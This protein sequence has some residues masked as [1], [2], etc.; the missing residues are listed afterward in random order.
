MVW[1]P[2]PVAA[3]EPGVTCPLRRWPRAIAALVTALACFASVASTT[4]AEGT[5]VYSVREGDTIFGLAQQFGVSP[6]D[7]AVQNSLTDPNVLEIGQLLQIKRPEPL[8]PFGAMT[9][10]RSDLAERAPAN[11]MDATPGGSGQPVG[12]SGGPILLK[13]ADPAGPNAAAVAP[14]TPV[15]VPRP[16]PP[17]PRPPASHPLIAA[18]YYS[19]FDGTVWAQSNCGPT[20][21]SMAL[22]ALGV[23][24]DQLTLRHYADVQMGI[25]NPD[26]GTTWEALV[27]AAK[28]H[29]AASV[30]L[31]KGKSYRTWSV[32]ALKS[33]L[34]KG[35]PVILLVRY[36]SLPDHTTSAYWGDHYIVALGFDA[37]GDLVYNDPAFKDSPGS[38]RLI[39]PAQLQKAWSHT[40][41]GLTR[42]AMALAR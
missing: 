39:N 14:S 18:P 12:S 37:S 27:Y 33:E 24:V 22:G 19:Q 4:L 11:A 16:V 23:T 30:G 41:I 38:D 5:I 25:S 10:D 35:H 2:T 6:D 20:A 29:G 7:I 36:A 1:S 3:P 15:A 42:T 26:D 21:L 17:P 8:G 31:Y 40:A 34:A 9:P 32:D 13:I 28:T